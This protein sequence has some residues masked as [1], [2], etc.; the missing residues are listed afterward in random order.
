MMALMLILISTL[1]PVTLGSSP[2]DRSHL[3]ASGLR[4]PLLGLS[5]SASTLVFTEKG[6][7]EAVD[8]AAGICN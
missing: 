3:L 6:W 1:V 4:G 2:R 8:I 5:S 7:Y